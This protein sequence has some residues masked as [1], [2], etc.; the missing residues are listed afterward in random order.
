MAGNNSYLYEVGLWLELHTSCKLIE[1]F[2][3][4]Q[5]IKTNLHIQALFFSKTSRSTLGSPLCL[6]NASKG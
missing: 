1:F 5:N 3:K 2:F 6:M 4:T